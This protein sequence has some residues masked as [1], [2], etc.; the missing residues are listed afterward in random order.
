MCFRGKK[1]KTLSAI[2]ISGHWLFQITTSMTLLHVKQPP[3]LRNIQ[4]S[5]YWARKCAGWQCRTVS[6]H[7]AHSCVYSCLGV[8]IWA[9]LSWGGSAVLLVT[10]MLLL[11]WRVCPGHTLLVG[12]AQGQEHKLWQEDTFQDSTASWLLTDTLLAK[13]TH[14]WSGELYSSHGGYEEGVNISDTNLFYP[15][16]PFL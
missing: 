4:R 13:T 11:G 14:R 12:M 3:N 1:H 2:Y 16:E 6:L 5:I 8:L 15:V 10:F 7:W 9:G